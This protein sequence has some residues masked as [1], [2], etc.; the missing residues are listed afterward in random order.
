MEYASVNKTRT[1]CRMMKNWWTWP[2][3]ARG[4][5][6][7]H[8]RSS[9]QPAASTSDIYSRYLHYCKD[10]SLR[11]HKISLSDCSKYFRHVFKVEYSAGR[12]GSSEVNKEES[13]F[14]D[15]IAEMSVKYDL[16]TNYD[17]G[18]NMTAWPPTHLE[19][20]LNINF[21]RAPEW[22]LS[23]LKRKDYD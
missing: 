8:T 4:R 10:K 13:K 17:L 7:G 21:G 20:Q 6:S 5:A 3:P 19:S 15:L 12:P 9:S 1:C 2:Y 16:L 11:A 14:Y 18:L 23:W 22:T